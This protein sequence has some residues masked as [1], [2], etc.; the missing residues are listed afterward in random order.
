[1]Q[2]DSISMLKH[3]NIASFTFHECVNI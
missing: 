3:I 1:M 2:P